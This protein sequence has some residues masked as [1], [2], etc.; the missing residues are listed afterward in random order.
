MAFATDPTTNVGATQS[1]TQVVTVRSVT[2]GQTSFTSD[3]FVRP[4]YQ[5][6]QTDNSL[7]LY[8]PSDNT[9][10]ETTNRAWQAAS[11][12]QLERDQPK[13]S[14]WSSST[15][16]AVSYG[17]SYVPGKTSIYE[18]QLRAH[19][20]RLASHTEVDGRAALKLVP[21]RRSVPVSTHSA[22]HLVLGTVYVEPRTY[23][24]IK[25]VTHTGFGSGLGTTLV[26][27]W[28]VYKVLPATATNLKLLS[29]T[30]RHPGA[31]VVHS[32]T[33][34]LAASNSESKH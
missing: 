17:P 21:T 32:A 31:R 20:Y 14:Q 26:E 9:I 4:G 13:G 29:L 11:L 8:D 3:S 1:P 16:E 5:Q 19:L 2:Y 27:D 7:E 15:Q 25:E 10:Y 33:G 18:Q 23:Y 6:V 28:L 30:A 12:R 22:I 24:P 34:Y